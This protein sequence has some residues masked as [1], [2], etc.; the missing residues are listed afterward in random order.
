M[1]LPEW[2]PATPDTVPPS[3]WILVREQDSGKDYW[4]DPKSLS[5]SAPR[6]ELTVEQMARVQHIAK[7]FQEHDPSPLEMWYDNMQRDQNP[8][9][10]IQ[11]W[12]QI[13]TVY[14]AE[15]HDRPDANR[16]QRRLL[17]GVLLTASMLSLETFRA[18]NVMSMYPQAKSL[19]NL[20]RVVERFQNKRFGP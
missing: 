9:V 2:I 20:E 1:A 16:D 10:E 17:F 8:E 6:S 5:Q 15:L 11:T 7:V 12:E 18:G 3:G 19:P 14:L 4:I 13:L